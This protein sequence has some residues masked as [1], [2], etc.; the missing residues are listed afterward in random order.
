MAGELDVDPSLVVGA[1]HHG[2]ARLDVATGHVRLHAL[3]SNCDPQE[4]ASG[5]GALWF[6]C[7]FSDHVYRITPAGVL[8]DFAVPNHF[9]GSYPDTVE[10][11]VAGKR[12]IWFSE[13][14]AARIGRIS[15]R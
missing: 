5:A 12:A 9:G 13:E 2:L 6:G 15:T 10:G 7:Y 11:I 4:I 14:A 8:T 1:E 3:G